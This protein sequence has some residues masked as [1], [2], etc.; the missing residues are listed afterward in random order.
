MAEIAGSRRLVVLSV[1]PTEYF[2][3]G[4]GS[5]ADVRGVV[6]NLLPNAEFE[7]SS[8]DDRTASSI[9]SRLQPPQQELLKN[10]AEQGGTQPL[11]TYRVRFKTPPTTQAAPELTDNEL[12]SVAG[13]ALGYRFDP[14]ISLISKPLL[15]PRGP[16]SVTVGV[17]IAGKF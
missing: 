3:R 8:I 1:S 11:K 2:V 15:N 12:G 17:G 14:Q 10:L 9:E 5:E 13:G 6:G 7:L 16:V 4:E